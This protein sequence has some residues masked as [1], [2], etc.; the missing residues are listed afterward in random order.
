MAAFDKKYQL[1]VEHSDQNG[2]Y[3]FTQFDTLEE[4]FM[5]PKMGDWYI[6]KTASAK[7]TD[8]DELPAFSLSHPHAPGI[9]SIEVARTETVADED[10][11]D[12]EATARYLA[13]GPIAPLTETGAA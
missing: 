3:T 2:Y 7:I 1:W 4:C 13:G 12:K 6:T 5:A 9:R 10:T 11:G 8:A